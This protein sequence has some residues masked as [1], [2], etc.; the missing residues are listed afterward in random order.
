[1]ANLTRPLVKPIIAVDAAEAPLYPDYRIRFEM[2]TEGEAEDSQNIMD[3]SGHEHSITVTGATHIDA[4]G[5]VYF[6][7]DGDYYTIDGSSASLSANDTLDMEWYAEVNLEAGGDSTATIYNKRDGGG[8]EEYRLYLTSGTPEF[9]TSSS[10]SD[11]DIVITSSGGALTAGVWYSIEV[12]RSGG[13]YTMYVDESD[14]GTDTEAA[15]PESNGQD[16]NVG[17]SAFNASRQFKGSMR[18]LKI[19]KAFA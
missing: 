19:T 1:M 13:V 16:L 14:V 9:V 18:N 4:D 5:S 3:K 10:S 12:R 15:I 7:G 6:D 11:T 17:H 8:S 2:D